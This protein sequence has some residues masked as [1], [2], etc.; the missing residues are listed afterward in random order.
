[1]LQC[2]FLFIQIFFP[3]FSNLNLSKDGLLVLQNF[4][5]KYGRV[6]TK[7][8]RKTPHWSSSKFRTKF[9]LEFKEPF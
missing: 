7:I 2:R 8:R 3:T 9:E 5:I 1:M 6:Y 4:E